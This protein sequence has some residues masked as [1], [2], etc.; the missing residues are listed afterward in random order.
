MTNTELETLI[1]TKAPEQ[2]DKLLFG[3]KLAILNPRLKRDFL[4]DMAM[5]PRSGGN[6]KV[7]AHLVE[8]ETAFREFYKEHV[9]NAKVTPPEEAKAE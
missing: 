3:M 8:A 2:A 5:K 9:V 1:Q 6:Q 7:R 4:R